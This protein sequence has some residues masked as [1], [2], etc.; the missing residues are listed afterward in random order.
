[1]FLSYRRVL[2]GNGAGTISFTS[3][4]IDAMGR[5]GLGKYFLFCAERRRVK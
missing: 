3:G 2:K 1:M 4:G 5:Y